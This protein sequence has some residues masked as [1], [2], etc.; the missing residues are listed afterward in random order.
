MSNSSLV[1]RIE[2]AALSARSGDT[3]AR[4][5][6]ETLRGNGRALEGMPYPL[7]KEMDEL[8]MDLQIACWDDEEGLLPDVGT[9]LVQLAAWL[10]KVPREV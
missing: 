8:I 6:A 10:S 3:S 1:S 2:G 9:V 5:L 7:I 4:S